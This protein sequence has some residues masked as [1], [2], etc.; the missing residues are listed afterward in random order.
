MLSPFDTWPMTSPWT[1]GFEVAAGETT[2]LS[3]Q[4]N[5]P[6][7]VAPGRYW[8]LIKV[9]YFGRLHYTEAIAVEV[10]ERTR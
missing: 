5:V 10:S 1:Q 7:G 6:R 2:D 8:V 9:M 4:I 3:F